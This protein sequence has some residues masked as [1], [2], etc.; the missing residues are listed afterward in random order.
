MAGVFCSSALP[1]VFVFAVTALLVW[2]VC[3]CVRVVSLWNG[4]GGSCGRKVRRSVYC[5]LRMHH[6]MSGVCLSVMVVCD[7][8]CMSCRSSSSLPP[9]FVFS[10][11][12]Y[13]RLVGGVRG[14]ARAA[15]RARTLSPNTTVS[16]VYCFSSSSSLLLSVPR[17][18]FLFAFLFVG[19]AVGDSPR[20]TVLCR[21][22]GNRESVSFVLVF[23]VVACPAFAASSVAASA[24]AFG[25]QH[26]PVVGMVGSS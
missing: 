22:D 5:L 19:I 7:G 10:S 12:F 9:L 25:A 6:N 15:L 26:S 13:L 11:S 18:S 17:S 14:S 24:V 8:L 23:L 16:S 3:L 4:G 1:P 2:C 20:V 21:H